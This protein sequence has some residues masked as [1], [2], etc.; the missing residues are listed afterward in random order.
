MPADARPTAKSGLPIQSH[1]KH[2]IEEVLRPT[3]VWQNGI[4]EVI[5]FYG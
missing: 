2:T 5:V 1:S 4:W 3:G